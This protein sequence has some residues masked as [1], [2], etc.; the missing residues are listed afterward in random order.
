MIPYIF[1]RLLS[2][3]ISLCLASIVIFTVVEVAPG[4]PAAFML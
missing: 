1:K 4:D 3:L 2:L